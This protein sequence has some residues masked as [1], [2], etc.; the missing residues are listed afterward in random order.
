[1]IDYHSVGTNLSA[2]LALYD[3]AD[4]EEIGGGVGHTEDIL[5]DL[6]QAQEALIQHFRSAGI[7]RTRDLRAY[8]DACVANLND[9]QSRARFLS[10]LKKLVGLF[11]ALMPRPEAREFTGDVKLYTYIAKVASNL[12]RD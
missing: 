9:T 1:V 11:D 7:E 5:P 10:L 8:A 3:A 4:Q 2:A 6:R 12:Y